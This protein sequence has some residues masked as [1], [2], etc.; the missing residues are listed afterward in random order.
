[1]K[2]IHQFLIIMAVSFIGELL[3]LLLP[4]PI[5]ASVYGLAIMLICL[6]T[7]LIKLEQ[8][9]D[10]ADWLILIMPVLFVPSAVSLINVGE[11][12]MKDLLVIAVVTLVSTIVVMVVT[13]KVAQSIIERK[14]N[15]SNG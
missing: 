8:I 9:E 7:K 6:F 1:M 2:Y 3:G 10:I 14:E 13:G 4:L 11:A 12:I 5:P 15:K